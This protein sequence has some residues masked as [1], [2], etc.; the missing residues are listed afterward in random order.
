MRGATTIVPNA[1]EAMGRATSGSGA[2]VASG[3]SGDVQQIQTLTANGS[4]IQYVTD[5][6]P[7]Q[8]AVAVLQAVFGNAAPLMW[9]ERKVKQSGLKID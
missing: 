7:E 5:G 3:S 2:N 4:T 1:I 8:A 9:V 6:N